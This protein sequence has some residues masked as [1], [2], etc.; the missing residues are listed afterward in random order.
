LAFFAVEFV[1]RALQLRLGLR[2]REMSA[3]KQGVRPPA[4]KGGVGERVKGK[5]IFH[6]PQDME[7]CGERVA[8]H[9]LSA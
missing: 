2:D 3:G 8:Y 9:R 1:K 7:T 6:R 4:P 5:S